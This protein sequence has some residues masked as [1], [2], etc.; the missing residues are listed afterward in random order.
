MSTASH[1][2][3]CKFT[4][5]KMFCFAF[6]SMHVPSMVHVPHV[7]TTDLAERE[8]STPLISKCATG[9]GPEPVVATFHL[10]NRSQEDLSF[11]ILG[12]KVY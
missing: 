4:Y 1:Q 12:L 2:V 8:S 5:L 7:E 3:I 9:H 11:N 6:S 10:H